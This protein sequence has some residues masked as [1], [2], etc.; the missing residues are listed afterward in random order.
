MHI[1]D[2][3]YWFLW[4]DNGWFSQ[5]IRMTDSRTLIFADFGR[6]F[7]IYLN[8]NIFNINFLLKWTPEMDSA[9]NFRSGIRV[10]KFFLQTL[11]NDLNATKLCPSSETMT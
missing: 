1:G 4:L 3:T 8:S 5:S 9:H 7:P 11:E 10:F 2:Q 6:F